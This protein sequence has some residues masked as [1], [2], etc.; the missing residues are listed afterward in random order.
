MSKGDQEQRDLAMCVEAVH[1]KIFIPS[2]MGTSGKI[3]T[4][5]LQDMPLSRITGV[6]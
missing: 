3:Y 2:K 1:D 6:T 4:E 5:M